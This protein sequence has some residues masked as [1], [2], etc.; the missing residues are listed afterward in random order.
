MHAHTLAQTATAMKNAWKNGESRTK[1]TKQV[2]LGFLLL[3]LGYLIGG[4]AYHKQLFPIDQIRDAKNLFFG[5]PLNQ[6]NDPKPRNTLF[7][8]FSPTA[9]VV[10]IGDSIIEGGLWSEIFPNIR[11][12][13]RG[14]GGDR[15]DDVL[16]RMDPIFAV[17]A[18]KAFIT[19]GINDIY[20]G[21]STE[22]I[23]HNYKDIVRKLRD[24]GAIVYIQS[25][26]ECSANKC[27]NKLLKTRELNSKLK[28]WAYENNIH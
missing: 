17:N 6:A 26:I 13:N 11:I 7:K 21:R 3:T 9:D 5:G 2:V 25:V 23:L 27:G 19:I 1:K 20:S 12:S 24:N 18:K 22:F 10:M 28:L 14:I 8:T 15:T 4:L 16:G